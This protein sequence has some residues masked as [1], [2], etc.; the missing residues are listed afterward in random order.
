MGSSLLP[1]LEA[2][3]WIVDGRPSTA[4]HELLV[5]IRAAP[6]PEGTLQRLIALAERSRLDVGDRLLSDLVMLAGA[7]KGLWDS[8]VRHPEWLDPASPT[9]DDPRHLVQRRMIDIALADLNGRWGLEEVVTSLSDLADEAL[10]QARTQ[11]LA[12]LE[13]RFPGIEHLPFSVIAL[14]KWGGREL[15][16]AS[17]IDLLFVYEPGGYSPDDSRRMA[18]KLAG[19]LI[20][21]LAA[22]TA[23]GIAFRV[24]TDLRPEGSTGPLIRTIDSYRAYYERWGESWEFQALLKARPAGGSPDLGARFVAMTEDYVWPA[25]ISP[26]SIRAL[27]QLKARAEDAADPDDIKRA[28]GGIRDIEF[29]VQLLQ[30]IHGRADPELRAPGTLPALAALTAGDYVKADDAQ[31][32]AESYRFLRKLEHR[33]QLW[34]LAQTHRVPSDRQQVARAMGYRD[35][36]QMAAAQFDAD[37]RAHRNRVRKLHELLYYRPLL[38]SFAAIPASHGYGGLS[39]DRAEARL[40]ALGFLDLRNAALAIENLTTGL[41]R[42]SRLMQQLLPLMVD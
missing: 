36:D 37:L 1:R 32:L 9:S 4:A 6:D 22:P 2:L 13:D 20:D 39:R 12:T 26:D 7:S 35:G 16:Y 19:A 28:P 11:V 8:L 25:S 23:E 27:R 34:Q 18:Q 30:L 31:A 38:E 17:D 14:G 29:S 21:R 24:D 5:S 40:E 42:R 33:L 41:S 3:G 10:A 15:N